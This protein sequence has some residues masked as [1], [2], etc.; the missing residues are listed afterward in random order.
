MVL[1]WFFGVGYWFC[2]LVF[3][4]CFCFSGVF[5]GG[6]LGVYFGSLFSGVLFLCGYFFGMGLGL[7]LVGF[8]CLDWGFVVLDFCCF[9]VGAVCHIGF[10]SVCCCFLCWVAFL[11]CW[12]VFFCFVVCSACCLLFSFLLLCGFCVWVCWFGCLGDLCGLVLWLGVAVGGWFGLF[13]CWWYLCCFFVGDFF[14]GVVF[15][16][17]LLSFLDLVMVIFLGW[18]WLFVV[19]CVLF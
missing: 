3:G 16:E 14:L 15:V 8:D 9:F 19:L 17:F 2:Y 12:C 7:F 18:L 11:G 5:I 10:L 1:W 4:I 6:L 13:F